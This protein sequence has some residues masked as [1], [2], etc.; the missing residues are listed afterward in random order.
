MPPL[1]RKMKGKIDRKW[2]EK[3]RNRKEKRKSA[4]KKRLQKHK[5]SLLKRGATLRNNTSRRERIMNHFL[6]DSM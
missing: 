2:R 3:G 4:V 6:K 1:G 5:K